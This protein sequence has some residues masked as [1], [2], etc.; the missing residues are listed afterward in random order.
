MLDKF[1]LTTNI[2]PLN[3]TTTLNKKIKNYNN[4]GALGAEILKSFEGKRFEYI[5]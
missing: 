1:L 3:H 4:G 5:E 2:V